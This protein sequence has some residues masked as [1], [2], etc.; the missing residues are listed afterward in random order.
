[1]VRAWIELVF[2]QS[3]QTA[4]SQFV[5]RTS[6]G[7]YLDQTHT[8]AGLQADF[9]QVFATDQ[10]QMSMRSIRLISPARPR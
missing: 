4:S 3:G 9:G 5:G 8:K 2:S 10:T 7:L 6:R 1:M